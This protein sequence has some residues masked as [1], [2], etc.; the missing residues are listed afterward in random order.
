HA[1]GTLGA[2]ARASQPFT[3]RGEAHP[4]L[5]GALLSA[6]PGLE[7]LPDLGSAQIS[8]A[9][10]GVYMYGLATNP[11][12][13]TPT[14]PLLQGWA[15]RA[16]PLRFGVTGDLEYY[17]TEDGRLWEGQNRLG[18]SGTENAFPPPF[19][20]PDI[21]TPKGPWWTVPFPDHM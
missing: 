21:G 1:R 14:G 12:R 18:R 20:D 16:W 13:D 7:P 4:G 15:L 5:R 19:Q 2:L 6:A 10:D 11:H 9:R 3:Q 8:Y 17:L